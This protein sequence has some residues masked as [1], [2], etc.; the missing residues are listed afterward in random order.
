MTKSERNEAID[1][2]Y[3]VAYE[4]VVRLQRRPPSMRSCD[5][6][7]AAIAAYLDQARAADLANGDRT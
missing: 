5:E 3:A 4:Q 1:L 7:Q 2:I 6:L